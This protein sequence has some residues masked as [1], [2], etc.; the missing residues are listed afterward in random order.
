MT[1]IIQAAT[2]EELDATRQLIRA[3]VAWHR[4]RHGEDLELIDRYFHP[5]DFDAEV[6]GLPGK[7][8]PPRGRLLLA[9]HQGRPAG[10]VALKPLD[11]GACEMKRMFVY[12]EFHGLG[13]GKSLARA[14]I[15]EA[16]A[17]GYD[18]MRLDTSF[19]QHEARALYERLGFRV[20]PPYYDLPDD[21]RAWLVFMELRLR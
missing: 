16:R 1:R 5:V 8:A 17:I 6:N 21:L 7:Y 2:E 12:T 19:R 11:D 9:I 14:L 15:D 13:I 4:Q 10:C 3:F 20:T 18:V